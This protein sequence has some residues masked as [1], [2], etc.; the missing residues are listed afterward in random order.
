MQG[1][2]AFWSLRLQVQLRKHESIVLVERRYSIGDSTGSDRS[3]QIKRD[4]VRL[5]A[6][7]IVRAQVPC[8]LAA[9]LPEMWSADHCVA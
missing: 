2:A 7:E 9:R 5:P 4:F 3:C 8:G 1:A 6:Q